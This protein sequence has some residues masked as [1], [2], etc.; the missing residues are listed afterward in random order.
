MYIT[1][2]KV[3][4]VYSSNKSLNN[5]I[6]AIDL[7]LIRMATAEYNNIRLGMTTKVDLDLYEDLQTYRYILLNKLLGCN[8]LSEHFLLFIVSRIKKLIR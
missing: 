7:K 3:S 5:L 8:C 1:P 2:T 4:D 6:K